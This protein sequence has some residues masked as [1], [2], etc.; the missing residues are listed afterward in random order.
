M[1]HLNERYIINNIEEPFAKKIIT[2]VQTYK[3][4]EEIYYS[5]SNKKRIDKLHV[6]DR[7]NLNI[8]EGLISMSKLNISSD[9]K[10]FNMI[11]LYFSLD[12][13]NEDIVRNTYI[14]PSDVQANT[15]GELSEKINQCV[16][17]YSSLRK[18]FNPDDFRDKFP[19]LWAICEK[20]LD[21]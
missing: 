9:T 6:L 12:K 8:I 19:D 4:F 15:K 13:I 10:I 16:K 18:Y 14:I 1:N 7:Y 17:I 5:K 11:N 2:L 21:N 20:K 3:S